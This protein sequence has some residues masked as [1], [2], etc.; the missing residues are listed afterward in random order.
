MQPIQIDYPNFPDEV[1]ISAKRLPR[2]FE[3]GQEIPKKYMY[4]YKLGPGYSWK[5][6]GGEQKMC[7][8]DIEKK[9]FVVKNPQVASRPR[10]VPIAGNVVMRMHTKVQQKVIQTLKAL[11]LAA[12]G[13]HERTDLVDGVSIP[14]YSPLVSIPSFPVRIRME[15]HTFPRFGKWDVDNLWI[16]TKCFQDALV[17]AGVL[18]GDD[19]HYVTASGQVEFFPVPSEAQRKLRFVIEEET[20]LKK[21]GHLLYTSRVA[22]G[23]LMAPFI[24]PMMSKLHPFFH[25]ETTKAGSPGDVTVFQDDHYT[26][27]Q[28]NVGK[29]S[30]LV[31]ET[32]AL[33][34]VVHQCFQMD[35]VPMVRTDLYGLLEPL[36]KSLFLD[37]GIPVHIYPLRTTQDED[38]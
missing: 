10:F 24:S 33:G 27:V 15:V 16:Y 9:A 6:R 36:F 18:P 8:W 3:K 22:T 23:K 29:T 38:F 2:Y 37:A 25:L 11:F 28:I 31:N 20:D 34:R 32:M 7:L 4:G 30:K 14:V 5:G 26:T 35:K 13:K 12:L 1:Q 19:I 17:T 21:T